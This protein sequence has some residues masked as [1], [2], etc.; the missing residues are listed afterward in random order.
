MITVVLTTECEGLIG[1]LGISQE[2]VMRTIN[3]RHRG[4]VTPGLDRITA[5]HWFSDER[6]VFVESTVTRREISESDSRVYF[7]EVLAQLAIGLRPELP[8]GNIRREMSMEDILHVVALSFGR[9]VTCHAEEAP[10]SLYFG[11]W[12]NKTINV[13][14]AQGSSECLVIGTFNTATKR[15]DYVW[16]FDL[17]MYRN[18]LRRIHEEKRD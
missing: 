10:T 11:P 5:V 9:P 12:D 16:A 1:S 13:E 18:W 7:K 17:Q 6:I 4:M 2:D 3:D 15:A 14:P 8:G